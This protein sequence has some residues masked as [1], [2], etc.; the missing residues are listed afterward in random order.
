MKQ[1]NQL[2]VYVT[3][4]SEL[5]THNSFEISH[6]AFHFQTKFHFQHL[7]F[8]SFRKSH[9]VNFSFSGPGI[10]ISVAYQFSFFSFNEILSEKP[11]SNVVQNRYFLEFWR[12]YKKTPVL[13]SPFNKI[14]VLMSHNFIK[15]LQHSCFPVT[16]GNFLEHLLYRIPPDNNF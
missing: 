16:F 10:K 4:L 9:S 5:L 1:R 6:I 7:C 14:A 13:E 12:I 15:K 3:L 8:C 11:F 2:C